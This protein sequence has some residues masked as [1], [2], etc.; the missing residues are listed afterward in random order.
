[1]QA[2]TRLRRPGNLET[3]FIELLHFYMATHLFFVAAIRNEL[4]SNK[5]G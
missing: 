1:M 3:G 2:V 4:L 5:T